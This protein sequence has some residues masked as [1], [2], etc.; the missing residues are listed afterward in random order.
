MKRHLPALLAILIGLVGAFVLAHAATCE[1]DEAFC[2]SS[3]DGSE[4]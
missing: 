4:P 1:Q 2:Y 3:N